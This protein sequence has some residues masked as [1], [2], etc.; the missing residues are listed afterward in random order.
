MRRF[1]NSHGASVKFMLEMANIADDKE[2]GT[3]K[4]VVSDAVTERIL[5]RSFMIDPEDRLYKDGILVRLEDGK[6][7]PKATFT[8]LAAFLDLPYCETMTICTEG[9]EP[10]GYLGGDGYAPGFS[11]ES[12]YRTYDDYANKD[13]RYFIEYFLR[14][15]YEYY[16][17][18]FLYYDGQP[19]DMEKVVELVQGFTTINH[20]MEETWIKVFREAEV[21]QDGE[22]V[23]D[24]LEERV[25]KEL[26]ENYINQYNRNRVRNAEILLEG[27]HFVNKNGQPLYMM[28]MLPLDPALLEKPLYH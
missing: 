17:Y 15:A 27:L 6:L 2:K 3:V 7:N 18:D 25:Q 16:G 5:N 28:P 12:I 19:V 11:P 9:G 24:E 23:N 4:T 10:V 13:E 8:A 20:Y 21:S 26:L 14:D 22:R 1:T